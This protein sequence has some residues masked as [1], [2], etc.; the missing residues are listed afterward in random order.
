MSDVLSIIFVSKFKITARLLSG[1]KRNQKKRWIGS[2]ATL[3]HPFVEE[4][5]ITYLYICRFWDALSSNWPEWSVTTGKRVRH[6]AH[7]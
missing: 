7:P 6:P 5:K 2:S 1:G 4:E 3:S